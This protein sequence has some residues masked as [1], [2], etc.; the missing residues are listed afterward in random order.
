[1]KNLLLAL[2]LLGFLASSTFAEVT[3]VDVS[4]RE[5]VGTSGYE[6]IVGTIH[7]AVNPSD[8]RNAVIVDLDRAPTNAGRVEFSADLYILRPKD[9]A[10][11]NGTALIEVSNRGNK[12]LL[13]LFNRASGG[14]LDYATEADLGDGFLTHQGYTLVWVGWQFD[15][16]RT[17]GRVSLDA[18]RVNGVNTL[19]TTTYTAN[20]STREAALPDFA[21]YTLDAS[22]PGATLTVRDG[23]YGEKQ[24]VPREAWSLSPTD[25]KLHLPAGFTL[26]RTY[27]LTVMAQDVAVA[28]VGL[29]A[30]RDT[31]AW[32][33]YQPDALA[34]VRTAYAYGSS[35]SGRF[36]RTFLY[37]GFNSDEKGRPVFDGVLAHIAG[38]ARLSLNE[39]GARPN[40]LKAP[41]P[42]F[43]FADAA[44]R[45]PITGKTDGLLE[46][47]RARANQPKIFYT[48]TS[49]EYWSGDRLAALVHTSPDGRTDLALPDNVRCYFLTGT[50]HGPSAFPPPT[51]T[52][53]LA[54]NPLEYAWTM[55]ALLTAM[56]RWVRQGTPPPASR[57]PKVADG[58]LVAATAINF[59][60]IPGVASPRAISGGRENG[61]PLP[62][63][64]PAVDADGNE[65]S[66][67]RTA[68]HAVAVATYT[69]WNF[70]RP[71]LGGPEQLVSLMGASIPFPPT[72][73]ARQATNDPRQSMAERYASKDKYLALAQ[74]HCEKLVAEGCLLAADIP[75]VMKRIEAQWPG[76]KA[77]SRPGSSSQD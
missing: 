1:M 40:T 16:V 53:Q 59:P 22:A 36:L 8:P 55:R 51:T 10:K 4:R 48:N 32:L 29:A 42:A 56:D 24:N 71:T 9:A 19:V 57:H 68:E 14:R 35:Q 2:A 70:R 15:V 21:G 37:Y 17:G 18:P 41:S 76:E 43:P 26:G 58:T 52:G 3:R 28:G 69:G 38:T 44:L 27:E 62:F 61:Q 6:K 64:V 23:P 54:Q 75:R 5:D 31:A 11:S 20:E 39:R 46:N 25:K 60:A 45:D 72:A 12:G 49:V 34:R 47:P 77:A 50:Q 30:F 13:S 73:S 7:F 65:R 74:A 63:L 66:G 67:I 33:K